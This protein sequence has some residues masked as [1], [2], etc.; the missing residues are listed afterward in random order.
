M[1][2]PIKDIEQ[3]EIKFLRTFANF[4]NK[5]VLEIGCGEGRLTRLYAHASSLTIGL[6]TD[7]DALRVAL[8]DS[9]HD[10]RN[11]VCFTRAQAEHLPFSKNKFDLAI[12]AWSF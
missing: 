3:N 1:M 9:P 11:K 6:D 10:L 7:P 2:T 5:R 12:L 4:A 8:I